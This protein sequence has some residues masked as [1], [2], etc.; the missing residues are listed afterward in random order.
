MSL[1]AIPK[2]FAERPPYRGGP[3]IT[4][5]FDGS[6]PSGEPDPHGKGLADNVR[7]LIKSVERSGFDDLDV[8]L[9]LLEQRKKWVEQELAWERMLA[10]QMT[11]P[12]VNGFAIDFLLES[13][14]EESN[15]VGLLNTL[16]DAIRRVKSKLHAL[17]MLPP[18]SDF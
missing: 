2:T 9:R 12:P 13:M 4:T 6:L 11:L 15:L 5:T 17:N 18:P 3:P 1:A 8:S 7:R 10:P 16:D 14:N